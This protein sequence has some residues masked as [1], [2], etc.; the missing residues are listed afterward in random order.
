MDSHSFA[1]QTQA[2]RFD[3]ELMRA[4]RKR[5]LE[6]GQRLVDVLDELADLPPDEFARRLGATLHYPVLPFE[7]LGRGVPLFERV[8]LAL[9]LKREFV[10]LELDGAT[11]GVFADP[12]DEAR[13]AWVEEQRRGASLHL[14]HP[15]EL[16]AF[17]ER[18]E[19][20]FHAVES[21]QAEAGSVQEHEA[22]ETLSLARISEDA[23]VVVK[24]VNSTLYDALKL[25]ASDIH[26]GMTGSGLSIKYRIDGVLGGSSRVPGAELAEQVI[27][28]VKVMAELDIG[29]K[30]VPQDGRFKIGINGRQ[31]DFRVSIMPSIFGEDA[32]LRVL[33]KQDLADQVQ[34]VRLEALGFEDATLR[35]LRRLA[36][37][38][39][40]M[41]LVTGPTGSGKTTTLYAMITEINH[42]MDKIITI[43][44]PV[45]YQLPG[46]LQIPVNEKKGLTFSRGLRSIL[47]HDPDKIMVGEIRDPDTAQIAVQS[48]LT[49]HLVFTTIHANNVFDVIGRFTQMEVD[50]YSFV[51][52]LNAVLAQR[53]IR[54]ACPHCAEAVQPDA[55]ELALS[56]IDPASADAYR[57]VRSPGCGH[58]RGTGYRGRTAI[59]ELLRLDDDLRQLIIERQPISR[60]KELAVQRG[61]R[62]LRTSALD[63]VREGRTTL[64]EINRVTFVA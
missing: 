45:E 12:F 53:L 15:R 14:V 43:E 16:A 46:V 42:G 36:A 24:L 38:P 56:G 5:S 29:E 47:R 64:E 28:R 9:A 52:A 35:S 40:G 10:L 8:P 50:P 60:I 1:A 17:L 32:V 54:L 39:Y 4:A 21:L 18:H 31:I 30:R 33:D 3:P 37:E 2:E 25:H 34:G 48:A 6:R 27:S 22:L 20:G 13:L 61:L 55:D 26:L 23:S 7:S 11:L 49:G 57:F 44:D 63:L 19:E 58:C 51:S 62:L 59:A 41:V